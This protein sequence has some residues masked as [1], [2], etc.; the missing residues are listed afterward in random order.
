MQGAMNDQDWNASYMYQN[1]Y[2]LGHDYAIPI[3]GDR[4]ITNVSVTLPEYIKL[5][6][7]NTLFNVNTYNPFKVNTYA[8]SDNKYAIL[9]LFLS[10]KIIY[11]IL[12]KENTNEQLDALLSGEFCTKYIKTIMAYIGITRIERPEFNFRMYLDFYSYTF[13]NRYA[14][15]KDM[16]ADIFLTPTNYIFLNSENDQ[17][18]TNRLM[19]CLNET[20]Q[21]IKSFSNN[22]YRLGTLM[23]IAFVYMFD[24]NDIARRNNIEIM[25]YNLGALDGKYIKIYNKNNFYTYVHTDGGFIGSV[26]RTFPLRQSNFYF[27]NLQ[28]QRQRPTVVMIRDAHNCPS[29]SDFDTFI[30]DDFTTANHTQY[31]W[32]HNVYYKVW[33]HSRKPHNSTDVLGADFTRGPIFYYINAREKSHDDLCIMSNEDWNNTFGK[34]FRMLLSVSN[35]GYNIEQAFEPS[36]ILKNYPAIRSNAGTHY[37]PGDSPEGNALGFNYGIDEFLSTF[38]VYDINDSPQRTNAI[39]KNSRWKQMFFSFDVFIIDNITYQ[40]EGEV[41]GILSSA[42]I[43]QYLNNDPSVSVTF[44]E[45]IEYIQ[46]LRYY[47][48]IYIYIQRNG[49]QTASKIQ[50]SDYPFYSDA[51]YGKMNSYYGNIKDFNNKLSKQ[52]GLFGAPN[53]KIY[54]IEFYL[55][56]YF[57]KL[58]QILNIVSWARDTI[59][60]LYNRIS[61]GTIIRNKIDTYNRINRSLEENDEYTIRYLTQL[62]TRKPSNIKDILNI[63]GTQSGGRKRRIRKG[64][65]NTGAVSNFQG[66]EPFKLFYSMGQEAKNNVQPFH[67]GA[68][69]NSQGKEPFKLLYS[70]GHQG[71]NDVHPLNT[72]VHTFQYNTKASNPTLSDIVR[73]RTFLKQHSVYTQEMLEKRIQEMGQILQTEFQTFKNEYNKRIQENFASCY[74]EGN[75]ENFYINENKLYNTLVAEFLSTVS[76]IK[77]MDTH[78]YPNY[79]TSMSQLYISHLLATLFPNPKEFKVVTLTDVIH[80]LY[81]ITENPI[82]GGRRLRKTKK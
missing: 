29:S 31:D 55:I 57:P 7:L 45:I 36:Y 3:Y 4:T 9:A 26:V 42:Y 30:K 69:S 38:C 70:M 72:K 14:I 27:N 15:T 40:I 52:E 76:F 22:E 68:V 56:D 75:V 51:L 48:D 63:D 47:K 13:L 10:S 50:T 25:L 1:T 78:T 49:N 16:F 41:F 2:N 82:S 62:T 24:G 12:C 58:D 23:V 21:I 67:M 80:I 71:K 8:P 77:E 79:E 6:N 34:V 73:S 17:A 20:K 44:K 37:R 60:S 74:G 64:G 59:T 5:L 33:W 53:K 32:V 61:L 54:F 11:S 81:L 35:N 19:E 65:F 18:K 66:K 28:L 46:T 43:Q 39:F